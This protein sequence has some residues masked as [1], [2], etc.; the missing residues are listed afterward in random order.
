MK[1]LI[2]ESLVLA[3]VFMMAVPVW[4]TSHH[5][6]SS[7]KF[8][9]RYLNPNTD[10]DG[11]G[12]ADDSEPAMVDCDDG[13]GIPPYLDTDSDNDGIADF[14]EYGLGSLDLDSS[15]SLDIMEIA[16]SL[17]DISP[18]NNVID[19]AELTDVY[20]GASASLPDADGDGL[21][22]ACDKDSDN[23]GL[24]DLDEAGPVITALDT[25]PD[26]QISDTEFSTSIQLTDLI[27]SDADSGATFGP[28]GDAYLPNVYDRDSDD[29]SIADIVENGREDCDVDSNGFVSLSEG[30]SCSFDT[31]GDGYVFAS[32][33]APTH[34]DAIAVGEL[35]P[36][37]M[38]DYIDRD[39]DG[40]G[41]A[42]WLEANNNND[43]DTSD[44]NID[45][46]D[47]L[48]DGYVS[49]ETYLISDSG[50]LVNTNGVG[51]AD[52]YV[53]DAD[54]DGIKDY[55]EGGS[56]ISD[57]MTAP[58]M[59]SYNTS[60][61]ILLFTDLYTTDGPLDHATDFRDTDSD[62]DGLSDAAEF[63]I[64]PDP[65]DTDL[66]GIP[67]FQ[68]SDSDDDGLADRDEVLL[69]SDPRN[70]DSDGDGCSDACEVLG[71]GPGCNVSNQAW[72]NPS[73]SINTPL[74]DPLI[75][76]D[77]DLDGLTDCQEVSTYQTNPGDKDT[78]GGGIADGI[79]VN[80]LGSN[81]LDKRDDCPSA[82][83]S[84]G[85]GLT[86]CEEIDVGLNPL[87]PDALIQGSGTSGLFGLTGCRSQ[88]SGLG[89]WIFLIISLIVLRPS[90]VV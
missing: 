15:G 86:D 9:S 52:V 2:V 7:S 54:G 11:D 22:N 39:S 64:G 90:R 36:D 55:Q 67:D 6:G 72:F 38:A 31:D 89:F 48:L 49:D 46:A 47:G 69:G 8:Y 80:L 23:D 24:P 62:S 81:P 74:A 45:G 27:N 34:T 18:A 43:I 78:D 3:F 79:E 84:D 14:I 21:P 53:Q 73:Y 75:D 32:E 37:M 70:K 20:S 76:G 10:S 44:N 19:L 50:L 65:R 25:T 4:G 13:D 61:P 66:D 26:N 59:P 51:L 77:Q 29:D 63:G 88:S 57:Y 40:D 58:G 41:I 17:L 5:A 83:D 28:S 68:D 16:S 82:L 56:A 35:T 30:S 71:I 85:D 1:R 87:E 12:I 60:I 42:D 33:L